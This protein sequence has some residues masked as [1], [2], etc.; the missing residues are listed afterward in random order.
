MCACSVAQSCLT[1]CNPMDCSPPGS[2]R[3]MKFSRQEYWSEFLFPVPGDLPVSGIESM[4]PALQADSLPLCHLGSP[5]K[6]RIRENEMPGRQGECL[7]IWRC[8]FKNL[9]YSANQFFHGSCWMYRFIIKPKVNLH[10]HLFYLPG[11]L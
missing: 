8:K 6:M 4:S 7:K 3:S 1:L 10:I 2:A 11:I 9:I 5:E